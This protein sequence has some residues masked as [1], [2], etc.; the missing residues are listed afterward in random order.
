MFINNLK[1][2]N[3]IPI[4]FRSGIEIEITEVDDLLQQISDMIK[5]FRNK[6]FNICKLEASEKTSFQKG[7]E[8]REEAATSLTEPRE[9]R[10]K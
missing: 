9:E 8:S 1:C 3:M 5:E 2:T 10:S 4:I 6:S 7:H